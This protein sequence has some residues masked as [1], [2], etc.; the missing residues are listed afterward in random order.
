MEAVDVLCGKE[1]CTS[2]SGVDTAHVCV[3][4]V[5]LMKN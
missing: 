1:A 2:Y 4:E 5:A 3:R